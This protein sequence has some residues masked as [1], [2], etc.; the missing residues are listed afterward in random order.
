MPISSEVMCPNISLGVPDSKQFLISLSILF[1]STWSQLTSNGFDQFVLSSLFSMQ[2][3]STYEINNGR[4]ENFKCD[5]YLS[6]RIIISVLFQKTPGLFPI[7][8]GITYFR[9]DQRT[10]LAHVTYDIWYVICDI[11]YVAFGYPILAHIQMRFNRFK[12]WSFK[13]VNQPAVAAVL[14]QRFSE[15]LYRFPKVTLNVL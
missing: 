15:I 14:N 3:D 13:M 10:N 6:A 4:N 7:T 5:N 11:S 12:I 2:Y 8:S 9:M 1:L